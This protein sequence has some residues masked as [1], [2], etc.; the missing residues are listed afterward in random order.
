MK[1]HLDYD[2][3]LVVTLKTVSRENNSKNPA[4]IAI[5]V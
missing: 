2:N 5:H 1:L 3:K 4:V